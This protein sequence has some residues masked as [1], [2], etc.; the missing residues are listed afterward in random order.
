MSLN[1]GSRKFL[2]SVKT[3]SSGKLIY[4]LILFNNA[5]S[6]AAEIYR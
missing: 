5:V 6:M 4:F 1:K 3:R 2:N